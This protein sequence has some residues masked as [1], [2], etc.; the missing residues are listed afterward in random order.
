MGIEMVAGGSRTEE[1]G[2]RSWVEVMGGRSGIEVMVGRSS[3]RVG[4]R[5]KRLEMRE[6]AIVPLVSNLK[7]T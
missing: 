4:K 2:V 1:M 6:G 3:K 7:K 5:S